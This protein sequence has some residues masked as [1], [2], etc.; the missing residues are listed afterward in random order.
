[1]SIFIGLDIFWLKVIYNNINVNKYIKINKI[2]N[3][4][5]SKKGFFISSIESL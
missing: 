2:E 5:E 3:K 4:K 1:M